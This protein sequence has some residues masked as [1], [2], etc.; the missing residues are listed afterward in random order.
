MIALIKSSTDAITSLLSQQ[1]FSFAVT[2]LLFSVSAFACFV[3][4]GGV[5]DVGSNSGC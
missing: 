3:S 5:S 4:L 1:S 2:A